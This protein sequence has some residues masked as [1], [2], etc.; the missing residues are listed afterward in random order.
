MQLQA[1]LFE[2][3]R[4]IQRYDNKPSML[5]TFFESWMPPNANL[6][7]YS[8]HGITTSNFSPVLQEK[9]HLHLLKSRSRDVQCT[10]RFNYLSNVRKCS[11]KGRKD[12]VRYVL[13]CERPFNMLDAKHWVNRRAQVAS[14]FE[15]TWNARSLRSCRSSSSIR[16]R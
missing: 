1:T 5:Q 9:F 3:V 6:L 2:K 12:F 7:P 15:F 14:G 10:H 8:T 16:V 4:T 11:R 13:N